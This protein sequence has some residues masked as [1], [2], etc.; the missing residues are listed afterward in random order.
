[1]V[2]HLRDFPELPV[3]APDRPSWLCRA[4]AEPWP[5]EQEKATLLFASGGDLQYVVLYLGLY[6]VDA[7]SDLYPGTQYADLKPLVQR[8]LGWV[9]DHPSDRP[10][11]S[12]I[13]DVAATLGMNL[14]EAPPRNGEPS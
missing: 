7:V 6:L 5:C 2:N 4:C 10:V 12:V 3:H 9:R 11:E 14:S 8:F 13:R 1:V